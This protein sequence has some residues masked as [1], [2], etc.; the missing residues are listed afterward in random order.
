MTTSLRA[1][2]DGKVFVPESEVDL[3][4]GTRVQV[5]VTTAASRGATADEIRA[6]FA[7]HPVDREAMEL[8]EKRIEEDC[9]RVDPNEW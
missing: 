4:V 3:P 2:F 7:R 8:I 9:G 1:K 6:L 5:D